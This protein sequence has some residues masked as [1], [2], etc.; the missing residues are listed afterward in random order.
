MYVICA[1]MSY[2]HVYVFTCTHTPIHM[3]YVHLCICQIDRVDTGFVSWVE[4]W[5]F[6][7]QIPFQND[8]THSL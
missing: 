8:Q 6:S 5:L 7:C 3:Y 4:P 2:I 1:C